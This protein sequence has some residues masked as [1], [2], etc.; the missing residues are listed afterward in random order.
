MAL[1]LDLYKRSTSFVLGFHGCDRQIGEAV[2]R[3]DSHLN[4]SANEYDWLGGGVYFWEGNPAR[5]LEFAQRAVKAESFT[6][7]GAIA[8]PFVVGAVL[9]LGMC[10]GLQDSACLEELVFGYE[11]LAAACK[12]KNV[13]LPQNLGRDEDRGQRLLDCAVFESMHKLREE[14]KLPPYDSVRATFTEGAAI[15][16]G[17]TFK[18]RAHTQ[19]AVRDPS[20]CVLGYFR[21]ID[22]SLR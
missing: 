15:Y 17:G 1:D 21:P 14:S 3:G 16:P 10:F 13:P 18:I 5:A 4:R 19:I 9:D 2:L 6:T 8:D 11:A 7:R 22:S 20:K 12:T